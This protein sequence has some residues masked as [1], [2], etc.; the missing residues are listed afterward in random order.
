MAMIFDKINRR[1]HLYLG[2]L[3][4]PWFLLYALSAVFLNHRGWFQQVRS[5]EPPWTKVFERDYR[6]PPFN[7]DSDQWALAEK[8]LKDFGMEG[9]YR[10]YFDDDENLVALRNHFFTTTRLTYYPAKGR[11]V[12]E[13]KRL[14]FDQ[15]LT[16]THFRSGWGYPYFL[17]MLWAVFVDAIALA[18]LV[19]IASGLYIWV[20]LKRLRFWGWVALAGG[21]ASFLLVVIAM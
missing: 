8:V 15:F 12:A 21:C 5:Q 7:D 9:R 4:T 13:E 11:I 14:R 3:L 10:A 18:T 16:S 1:T 19:W 6:L 2:I 20:K 17:E